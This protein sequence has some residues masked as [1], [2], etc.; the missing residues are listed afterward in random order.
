MHRYEIMHQCWLED[1][2]DRPCFSELVMSITN[3]T[4]PHELESLENLKRDY[5]PETAKSAVGLFS[6]L[7]ESMFNDAV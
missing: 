2:D 1:P 4:K 5:N 6:S 7:S 3:V